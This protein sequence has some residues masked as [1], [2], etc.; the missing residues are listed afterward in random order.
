MSEYKSRA[1]REA[2]AHGEQYAESVEASALR[3]HDY[4]MRHNNAERAERMLTRALGEAL[5]G[6]DGE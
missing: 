4:Y 3:M 5:V 6:N 1:A 2:L